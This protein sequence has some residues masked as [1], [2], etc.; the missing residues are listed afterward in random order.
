MCINLNNN[1]NLDKNLLIKFYKRFVRPVL[2]P[3]SEVYSSQHI[4]LIY[5]IENM[6]RIDL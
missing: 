5:F 6:Q 4:V 1:K 2:E 3:A